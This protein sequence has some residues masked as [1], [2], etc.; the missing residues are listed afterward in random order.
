MHAPKWIILVPVLGLLIGCSR[1]PT[2][3][4]LAPEEKHILKLASLYT[5]FRA[6]HGRPPNDIEDLQGFARGMSKDD[7]DKAFISPRDNQ[8]DKLV[9][10]VKRTRGGPLRWT[11][12]C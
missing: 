6:K 8:P 3:T 10:E 2:K 9:G 4:D 7:L 12:T 11:R 1:G 5:D